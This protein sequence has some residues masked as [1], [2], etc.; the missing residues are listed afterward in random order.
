MRYLF[1]I[2]CLG[3]WNDGELSS[4]DL[5]VFT[6][7]AFVLVGALLFYYDKISDKG[8]GVSSQIDIPIYNSKDI[9]SQEIVGESNFVLTERTTSIWTR[10]MVYILVVIVATTSILKLLTNG[11]LD[12]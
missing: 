12:Y 5:F 4:T 10:I 9:L 2:N 8:N 11:F 1:V 6:A 7:I 3:Y